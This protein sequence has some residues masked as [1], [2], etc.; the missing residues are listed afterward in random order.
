MKWRNDATYVADIIPYKR[1]FP[2]IMPRRAD[3][4]V[5]HKFA[6]NMTEGVK[7][8]K[9]MNR[10]QPGEHQYRVFELF[11]AAML[12][13]IAM[14]PHLNRFLMNYE[15]WQRNELSLNFVVKED[16]TDEAPEHSAILYFEPDM[17]FTEFATI[18]N[19][20]IEDSR[21]G[22]RDNETDRAIEFFLHFPKI[23]LRML[24]AIIGFIDRRG[25]APKALR[26]AD[27]LHCTA[28]V[29]NLGSINL[30]SSPHHH[31]WEWGTTS[32]FV[33]MGK[34][35]RRRIVD[36]E[37]N[38]T[39]EDTMDIGVTLDE[40]I[41]DGFYFIKTMQLLQDY[42][43]SPEKLM[44]RP[45]LPPRGPTL[46]EMRKKRRAEKRSRRASRRKSPSDDR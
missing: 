45:E 43:D 32:I 9:K 6:I 1:I 2:Y 3:S 38:R 40:R 4:L 20:N 15:T 12:R 33:T 42:L 23:I 11:L 46:K 28:F 16:Y 5:Y 14:R 29:A 19:K 36:E 18:I 10:E 39:F 44:E 8:V 22:G 25:I 21:A 41:A 17:I 13:T 34:L 27:G 26:D 30:Q 35:Q 37:G 31:L 7:F 24:V